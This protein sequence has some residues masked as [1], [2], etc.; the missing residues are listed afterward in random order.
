MVLHISRALLDTILVEA[1]RDPGFEACGLMLGSGPVEAVVPARNV[2]A[3]PENAFEI[4]PATLFAAIRNERAGGPRIIGYY[5]SHPN[6]DVRP[7][8]RDRS[9]ASPDGRIWLIVSGRAFAAW[10]VDTDGVFAPVEIDVMPCT[11]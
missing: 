6:G 7:S 4:D 2:A 9:Q 8:A 10:S 3:T 1:A 5:H 11:A